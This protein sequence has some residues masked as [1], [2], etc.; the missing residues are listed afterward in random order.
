MIKCKKKNSKADGKL[1]STLHRSTCHWAAKVRFMR[2]HA[3]GSNFLTVCCFL[4]ITEEK[5][6][7]YEKYK[8]YLSTLKA[9]CQQYMC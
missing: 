4:G 8:M 9:T 2:M 1:S 6:V 3:V 5:M 7:S